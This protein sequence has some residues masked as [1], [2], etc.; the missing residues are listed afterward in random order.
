MQIQHCASVHT[1]PVSRVCIASSQ[2]RQAAELQLQLSFSPLSLSRRGPNKEGCIASKPGGRRRRRRYSISSDPTPRC[3]EQQDPT[4][5]SLACPVPP[6]DTRFVLCVMDGHSALCVLWQGRSRA[7]GHAVRELRHPAVPSLCRIPQGS[8]A[9]VA[10]M[11]F[12]N[13]V[14][15]LLC[16]S[17]ILTRGI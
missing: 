4:T 5:D 17:G 9:C 12:V 8:A 16:F 1:L 10:T 7:S 2:I 6:V 15:F 13:R 3:H 11:C 14:C